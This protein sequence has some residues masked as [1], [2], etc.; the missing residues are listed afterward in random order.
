MKGRH[1]EG[2][3]EELQEGHS[4]KLM[5][6]AFGVRDELYLRESHRGRRDPGQGLE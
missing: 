4:S 3:S 6:N 1:R 2:K 5:A